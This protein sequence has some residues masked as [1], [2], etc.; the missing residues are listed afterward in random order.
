MKPGFLVVLKHFLILKV[1]EL[2]LPLAYFFGGT[3]GLWGVGK[4]L[5]LFVEP[6]VITEHFF[7]N[8]CVIVYNEFIMPWML[9]IVFV[10]IGYVCLSVFNFLKANWDEAVGLAEEEEESK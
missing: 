10:L 2:G 8:G 5:F 4:I 7:G 1:K 9:A 3:F 6:P